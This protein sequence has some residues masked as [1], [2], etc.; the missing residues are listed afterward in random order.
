MSGINFIM[1]VIMIL[2][3]LFVLM[4]IADLVVF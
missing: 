2:I 1:L 3:L 4:M